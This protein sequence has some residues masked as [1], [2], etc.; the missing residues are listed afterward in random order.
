MDPLTG[1]SAGKAAAEGVMTV[2]DLAPRLGRVVRKAVGKDE[3]SELM[4]RVAFAVRRDGELTAGARIELADRIGHLGVDPEVNRLVRSLIQEGDATALSELEHRLASVFDA[5]PGD[6]AAHEAAARVTH[7]FEHILPDVVSSDRDAA[8]TATRL[9]G[10]KIMRD[11]AQATTEV[12]EEIR[13]GISHVQET[14]NMRLTASKPDDRGAR[15]RPS[16]GR[17]TGLV[18]HSAS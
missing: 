7:W 18:R 5:L 11:V 9:V 10:G 1:I 12:K 3:F 4:R 14:L 13:A 2:A 6:I 17:L 8:V 16:N 15:C